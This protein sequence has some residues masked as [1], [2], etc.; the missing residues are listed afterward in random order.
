M[1]RVPFFRLVAVPEGYQDKLIGLTGFLVQIFDHNYLFASRERFEAAEYLD[2][3]IIEGE[4]PENL[5]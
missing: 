3:V 2:A 5:R 4:L 1:C